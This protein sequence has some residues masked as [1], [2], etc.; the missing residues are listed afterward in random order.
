MSLVFAVLLSLPKSADVFSPFPVNLEK[1]VKSLLACT[2]TILLISLFTTQTASHALCVHMF[3]ARA[4][5]PLARDSLLKGLC[6]YKIACFPRMFV[7]GLRVTPKGPNYGS[8]RK[9]GVA[10]GVYLP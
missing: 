9:G 8:R 2:I 1:A 10:A 6:L 5:W 7:N 4:D 3:F